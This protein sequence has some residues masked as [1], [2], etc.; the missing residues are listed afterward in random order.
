MEELYAEYKIGREVW[1][2]SPA[3]AKAYAHWEPFEFVPAEEVEE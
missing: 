1:G 2:M 3:E